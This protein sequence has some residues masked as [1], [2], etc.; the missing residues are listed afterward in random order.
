MTDNNSNSSSKKLEALCSE[1]FKTDTIPSAE[2]A[3]AENLANNLDTSNLVKWASDEQLKAKAKVLLLKA[4]DKRIRQSS[5]L[6]DV[7]SKANT[8][9][10][11]LRD[12]IKEQLNHLSPSERTQAYCR[13]FEEASEADLLE[14][15]KDILALTELSEDNSGDEL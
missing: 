15:Q 1:V 4:R 11:E 10:Q 5:I 7:K 12:W 2:E 6:S 13:E 9:V 14:M 3:R 8:T